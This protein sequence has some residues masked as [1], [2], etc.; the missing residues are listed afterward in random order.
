MEPQASLPA[1]MDFDDELLAGVV[2]HAGFRGCD[3]TDAAEASST[4][5]EIPSL[6]RNPR[7]AFC[8]HLAERSLLLTT[9]PQR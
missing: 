7:S 2:V 6:L 3:A 8:R 9:N 4:F 5:S 1:A